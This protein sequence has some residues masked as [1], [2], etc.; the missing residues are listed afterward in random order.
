MG[1]HIGEEEG[2]RREADERREV[3][4]QNQ[5]MKISIPTPF[6]F[7]PQLIINLKSYVS[8]VVSQSGGQVETY[9]PAD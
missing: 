7:L 8:P 9:P 2:R 1:M 5:G 6:L 4:Q 3:R